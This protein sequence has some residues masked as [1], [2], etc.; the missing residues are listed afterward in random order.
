AGNV[1]TLDTLNR[2]EIWMGPVW[3]DMFHTFML[4]GKLDPRVRLTILEP[5]LPGQPMYFVIPKNARNPEWAMKWVEYATIPEV[6]GKIIMGRY[7]WYPD[8][9]GKFVQ[10]IAP[11]AA[12]ERLYKDISPEI[13]S[14]YRQSFPI[15]DTVSLASPTPL[16]SGRRHGAMTLCGFLAMFALCFCMNRVHP[17][18]LAIG[19]R[20]VQYPVRQRRNTS[21]AHNHHKCGLPDLDSQSIHSHQTDQLVQ[22]T[23]SW[24][25]LAS[26]PEFQLPMKS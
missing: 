20:T 4:E 19:K 8:I 16:N 1:G 15:V 23:G 12:F 17:A 22:L 3:V 13:L 25:R 2:G 11:P 14:K 7:N 21:P 5:G 26:L 18:L 6:Q 9:D 24:H 10:D